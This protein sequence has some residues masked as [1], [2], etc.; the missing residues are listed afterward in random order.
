MENILLRARDVAEALGVAKSTAYELMA[1]GQL[2][3]VRI[4]RSVRVPLDLLRAWIGRQ[5]AEDGQGKGSGK[6]R[7]GASGADGVVRANL[8]LQVPRGIPVPIAPC[9]PSRWMTYAQ[10]GGVRIPKATACPLSRA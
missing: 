7:H 8:R 9:P 3:V 1:T 4:G 5:A 10:S 6:P 2:P